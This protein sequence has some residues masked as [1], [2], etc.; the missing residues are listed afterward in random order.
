MLSHQ[1]HNLSQIKAPTSCCRKQTAGCYQT[2]KITCAFKICLRKFW[3]K[4]LLLPKVGTLLPHYRC[5][6]WAPDHCSSH[7]SKL[8][9][10]SLQYRLMII[11]IR[12]SGNFFSSLFLLTMR[13][14]FKLLCFFCVCSKISHLKQHVTTFIKKL[15]LS[16][17]LLARK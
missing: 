1:H 7:P 4:P 12:K 9:M 10:G 5:F 13:A 3:V 15:L 2:H 8:I 17:L 6:G 16:V 11:E 14:I